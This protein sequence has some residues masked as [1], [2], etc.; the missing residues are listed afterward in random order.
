MRDQKSTAIAPPGRPREFDIDTVLS[1]I[2][3]LFWQHGY[4]ATTLSDIVR[5]TGLRKASL[6]AAFGNKQ[7]MYLKALGHYE[8]LNVNETVRALRDKKTP[9]A[10]RISAFLEQPILA[11]QEND[12][13]RGC[14]LCNASA[15]RASLDPETKAL[16]QNGYDKMRRALVAAIGE[17]NKTEKTVAVRKAE[18][19]NKAELVL[20]VYSGLRIMARSVTE[21]RDL[22]A[23]KTACLETL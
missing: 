9:A 17:L 13:R 5:Q 7:S 10:T 6:Y 14:F 20:T 8:N 12:D 2:M 4:E 15:D 22:T 16:V 18:V 23:A 21:V 1:E 3:A 19:Q 11:V